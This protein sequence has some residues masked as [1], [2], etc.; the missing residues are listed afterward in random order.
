MFPVA[1]I[2][3]LDSFSL[4]LEEGSAPDVLERKTY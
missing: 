4:L 1:Q 2:P 3:M